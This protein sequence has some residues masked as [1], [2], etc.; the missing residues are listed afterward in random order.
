MKTKI[1]GF[2]LIELM[3]VIAI[4]GILAA[5]ALPL[6][7]D[8]I[9]KSQLTRVN[10]EL[11]TTRTA[12]EYILASGNIPTV[13][14]A[15]DG[16]ISGSS[17]KEYIGLNK[18]K[19]QS[20]LIYNL[21]LT[22]NTQVELRAVMNQNAAT[23]IKNVVFIYSRNNFGEWQCGLDVSAASHWQQKYAPAACPALP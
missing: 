3:I 5:I 10:Y 21:S 1:R 4:I 2:T 15:E 6:Y 11:N 13:I 17:K 23:N 8:Y 22:L 16:M 7:Q 19:P 9:V 14:P 12:I 20:S 18:D